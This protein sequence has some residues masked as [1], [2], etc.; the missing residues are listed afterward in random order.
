MRRS[1]LVLGLAGVLV[2]GCASSAVTR[3]SGPSGSTSAGGSTSASGSTAPSTSTSA[4]VIVTP[5]A[6][7]SPTPTKTKPKYGF[8]LPSGP[9]APG[10]EL[11]VYGP[12]RQGDCNAAQ[13]SLGLPDQGGNWSSLPDPAKVLLFQAG[14]DA[15]KGDLSSAGSLLTL[16]RTLFGAT[17]KENSQDADSACPLYEALVSV[18][19]QVAPA[20]VQ[21]PVGPE[22]QWQS[23]ANGNPIDPRTHSDSYAQPASSPAASSPPSVTPSPSGSPVRRPPLLP[24]RPSLIR[25][26]PTPSKTS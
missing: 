3:A 25:L 23:D 13:T 7:P 19:D 14:V 16:D 1:V 11:L 4:L 12:L 26:A 15:C 5:T 22:P 10:P 8:G 17:T 2:S 18:L 9:T 6:T 24:V 21:C 20:S